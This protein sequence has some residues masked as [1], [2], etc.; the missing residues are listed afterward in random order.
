MLRL[1]RRDGGRL[2]WAKLAGEARSDE[3]KAVGS[4]CVCGGGVAKGEM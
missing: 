2:S 3:G 4:S 1:V